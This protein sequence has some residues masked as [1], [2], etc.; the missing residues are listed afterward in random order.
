MA[1]TTLITLTS[2]S[3][4]TD[5]MTLG[6]HILSGDIT[7]NT[8]DFVSDTTTGTKLGTAV[9]QKFAFFGITPVIQQAHIT[10][11]TTSTAGYVTIN[12][13]LADLEDYDLLATS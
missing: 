13:I 5:T 2:D 4:G 10:D 3:G 7:L 12:A 6:A 11:A 9:D 1:G 8:Q